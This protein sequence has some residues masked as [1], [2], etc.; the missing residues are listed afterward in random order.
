MA[1]ELTDGDPLRARDLFE[2]IDAEWWY[3]AWAWREERNKAQEFLSRPRKGH[4]NLPR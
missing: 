2:E 3:R 4:A 1:L